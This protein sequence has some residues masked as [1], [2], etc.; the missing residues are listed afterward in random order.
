[1]ED[2]LRQ[3]D[4]TIDK[5]RLKN[6]T[7]KALITKMEHQLAHKEEMGE[8]GAAPRSDCALCRAGRQ[9]R[10][11]SSSMHPCSSCAARNPP[12]THTQHTHTHT[13]TR[14]HLWAVP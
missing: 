14:M 3:K 11:A 9:P 6:T 12:H 13:R 8:V 1:M 10:A 2:K 5:M 4:A 7:T